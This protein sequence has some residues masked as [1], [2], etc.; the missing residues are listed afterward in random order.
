MKTI[1]TVLMI[2]LISFFFFKKNNNQSSPNQMP[3]LKNG[4]AIVQLNYEWNKANTYKWVNTSGV[5]YYYLS[6]DK[7]PYEVKEQFKI[8]AVP[9]IIVLNNGKEV[10]RYDGGMMMK[11]DVPQSEILK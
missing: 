9:T 10:K 4:K 11:I 8:K 1:A 3:D 7:F 2:A 6:L 5:K